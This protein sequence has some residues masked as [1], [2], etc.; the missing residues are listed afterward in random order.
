[1]AGTNDLRVIFPLSRR[2]IP[3][4]ATLERE[5]SRRRQCASMLGET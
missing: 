1:M 5:F 4:A 3:H 2:A